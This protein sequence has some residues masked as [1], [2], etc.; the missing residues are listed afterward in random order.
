[1]G[2]PGTHRGEGVAIDPIDRANIDRAS[3]PLLRDPDN[4]ISPDHPLYTSLRLSFSPTQGRACACVRA[5]APVRA[6]HSHSSLGGDRNFETDYCTFDPSF[7]LRTP[8]SPPHL[9]DPRGGCTFVAHNGMNYDSMDYEE[10]TTPRSKV[11]RRQECVMTRLLS[12]LLRIRGQP[13]TTTEHCSAQAGL[14]LV[15]VCRQESVVV[16]YVKCLYY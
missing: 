16:L 14:K 12:P 11:V 15:Y 9:L 1:M 2:T 8:R 5:C 3:L 13:V 10:S 4:T 7:P 6:C